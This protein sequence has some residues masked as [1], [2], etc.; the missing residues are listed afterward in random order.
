MAHFYEDDNTEDENMAINND[1]DLPAG[2]DAAAAAAMSAAFSSA[3]GT[4]KTSDTTN[5]R[6]VDNKSKTPAPRPRIATIHNM[7]KSSSSDDEEQGQAF[8]TGTAHSGQQ[9][10]GP[11]K[12]NPNKD[13]VSE[14][15][16][17][18]QESGAEVVEQAHTSAS[19]AGAALRYMYN[20]NF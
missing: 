16:R 15:F 9:I 3:S 10:L 5:E 20:C 7:T 13:Y 18:A 8:Y 19:A 2:G 6:K 11:P 17:S 1:D 14:V 12:K 4:E